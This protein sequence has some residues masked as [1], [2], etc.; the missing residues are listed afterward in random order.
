[1]KRSSKN[2]THVW[3][4]IQTLELI[5]RSHEYCSVIIKCIYAVTKVGWLIDTG[6]ICCSIIDILWNE[7]YRRNFTVNL[8]IISWNKRH[9]ESIGL[10]KFMINLQIWVR[11][12]NLWSIYLWMFDKLGICVLQHLCWQSPFKRD[13]SSSAHSPVTL[14]FCWHRMGASEAKCNLERPLYVSLIYHALATKKGRFVLCFL[15]VSVCPFSTTLFCRQM[16]LAKLPQ[17]TYI[18]VFLEHYCSLLH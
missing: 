15:C 14:C 8:E 18:Y 6:L 10:F 1:M 13:W 11:L 5:T 9:E 4:L 7:H 12:I 2:T 3:S 17:V 16:F